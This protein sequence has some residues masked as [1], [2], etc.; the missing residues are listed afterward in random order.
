M[1]EFEGWLIR[2]LYGVGLDVIRLV[3]L[4]IYETEMNCQLGKLILDVFCRLYNLTT[5]L[6]I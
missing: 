4:L 3:N 1:E 2:I 6:F 5:I